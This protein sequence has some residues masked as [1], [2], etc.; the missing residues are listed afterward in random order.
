MSRA[1]DAILLDLDGTLLTDEGRIHPATRA[2]LHAAAA[3]GVRVVLATG[4]SELG[5]EPVVRELGL[6]EPA[7]VYNGAAVWDPRTGRLLEERV[8]SNRTVARVL[9]WAGC[10]G[11]LTIAM[12]AG[13][14]VASAPRDAAEEKALSMLEGLRVSHEALP[15]ENLIRL[16]LFSARHDCSRAFADELDT[17]LDLPVYVTHFPLRALVDH[18]ESELDVLDVQPPCRGKGEA[19]RFV[20]ET[21]GIPA[22]RCV[23]VGDA[24]NDL[25]MMEAAGLGVA[26]QGSFQETLERA[27]RVIGDNNT[28]TIAELVGE[29]FGVAVQP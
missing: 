2:A 12:R 18:K 1:F 24:T 19:L 9:G 21:Y 14:K 27:D 11:Y 10:E 16:T 15:T 26:M 23:A 8:L 17:V 29:L 28:G 4:R 6:D 25:P 7:V 13:E 3:D 5:A 22:A 20:E